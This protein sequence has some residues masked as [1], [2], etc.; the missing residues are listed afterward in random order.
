MKW[1][2]VYFSHDEWRCPALLAPCASLRCDSNEPKGQRPLVVVMASI[3]T[4]PGRLSISIAIPKERSS[5]D[6][7]RGTYFSLMQAASKEVWA[8]DH[9]YIYSTSTFD[10]TRP[11]LSLLTFATQH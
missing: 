3:P 1:L 11:D 4:P 7:A 10:Q 9:K 6:L 2:A 8:Y 5:S